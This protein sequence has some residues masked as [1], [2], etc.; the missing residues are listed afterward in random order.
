MKGSEVKPTR[1]II[2]EKHF[3]LDDKFIITNEA[4]KI[5]YTVDSKR[6]TIGDK[7]RLYDAS[8]N[9]LIAIRQENLHLHSTYIIYSVRQD[10]DEMELASIKRTGSFLHH[11]LE[12]HA[13]NGE[14]LMKKNGGALSHEFTLT[15]DGEIIAVVTKDS[16]ILK[17]V[18]WLD[19]SDDRDEYRALVM[20]MVI[21]L[22]CVSRLPGAPLGIDP[23]A[24]FPI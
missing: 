13:V 20:A 18:F 11:Q 23:A 1:Y 9:E 5:H 7:L 4:G 16:S 2:Q 15:K 17:S 14:Y 24:S 6:F 19:I 3:S 22:S 10:V 21:V 12:I 8:G